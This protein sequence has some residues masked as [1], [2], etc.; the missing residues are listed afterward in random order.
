MS[1]TTQVS[2]EDQL[3]YLTNAEIREEICHMANVDIEKKFQK[4][5]RS[6]SRRF[7]NGERIE[8]ILHLLSG[9]DLGPANIYDFA[10]Q[11][12]EEKLERANGKTLNKILDNIT[13]LELDQYA[14]HQNGAKRL[15]REELKTLY[16]HLEEYNNEM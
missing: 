10:Q 4:N 2:E 3:K 16:R 8:I 12:V 13:T 14:N 15:S 5:E 6:Q 1:T 11:A 9:Y 7:T